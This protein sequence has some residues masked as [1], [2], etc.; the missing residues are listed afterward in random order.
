MLGREIGEGDVEAGT[1]ILAERGRAASAAD[2]LRVIAELQSWS[3]E[4]AQWWAKDFDLLIT[5]DDM[6]GI[7]KKGIKK[8]LFTERT[9]TDQYRHTTTT[10]SLVDRLTGEHFETAMKAGVEAYAY[11]CRMSETGIVIDREIKMLG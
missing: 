1:L 9:E 4:I 11:R 2:Y 10:R 8:A 6:L 3:R 7:V 5:P